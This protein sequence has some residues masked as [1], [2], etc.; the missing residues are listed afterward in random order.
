MIRTLLYAF[1]VGYYRPS[2]LLS[3]HPSGLVNTQNITCMTSQ[4]RTCHPYSRRSHDLQA[5]I[6]R[7]SRLVRALYPA[8]RRRRYLDSSGLSGAVFP[9]VVNKVLDGLVCWTFSVCLPSLCTFQEI[10]R[11]KKKA[12]AP[13]AGLCSPL[14]FSLPN[15]HDLFDPTTLSLIPRP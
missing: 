5:L 1:C 6:C 8:S 7:F 9:S 2:P 4:T 10:G 14:R 15:D 11:K 3:S 12:P 13:A